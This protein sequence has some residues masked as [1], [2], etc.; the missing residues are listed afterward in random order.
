[1]NAPFQLL[2]R[3]TLVAPLGLRFRDAATGELVGGGLSVTIHPTDDPSRRATGFVNRSGVYVV[4]HAAGLR[5]VEFGAGDKA[6]WDAP[7]TKR[8]FTV[9]V[10]DSEGRFLPYSFQTTLPFKGI[11]TWTWPLGE[12]SAQGPPEPAAAFSDDFTDNT[13][14]ARW[15]LGT[16]TPPAT[17]FDE[18]VTVAETGERLEITPRGAVA[19]R[20]YNGYVS[21]SNWNLT[22]ARAT[23]EVVETTTNTGQTVFTLALDAN[24]WFR[25][26]FESAKLNFQTKVGGAETATTIPA[27]AAQQRFWR[28]RHERTRDQV[29]FET[30]ADGTNWVVRREVPRQFSLKSMTIELN[31]GTPFPAASP[32][33]AVFDSFVLE[34]NPTQSLPLYSSPTRPVTGGL[35]V[36]RASLWDAVADAPAAWALLEARV[37]GQPTVRGYADAEGRVALVFPYPEPPSFVQQNPPQPATPFTRQ[38]WPVSIFASYRPQSPAPRVP[39]LK[40]TLAQPRAIL[41]ADA[42]RTTPLTKVTLRSGQQLVV[43]SNEA[44]TDA[45]PDS[46]PLPVLLISPAV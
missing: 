15:N 24:N 11:H 33:R 36:L 14:D 39:D 40:A 27:D 46:R 5:E 31:A 38:E 34:S 41:W 23:V 13:R 42:T 26:L 29:T 21:A 44:S 35:A 37:N 8:N 25:F 16:L 22:D 4:S 10:S 30:S 19:G 12:A 20:A 28:L 32:G 1:M 2:E 7:P 6:F 18:Q 43:R 17:A 45:A 9:E 3:Q